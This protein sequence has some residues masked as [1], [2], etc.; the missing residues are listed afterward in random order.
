MILR[1]E[2]GDC[3]MGMCEMKAFR[4]GSMQNLEENW[5]LPLMKL[6]WNVDWTACPNI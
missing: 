4:M 5:K 2:L 1:S 6:T 3:N